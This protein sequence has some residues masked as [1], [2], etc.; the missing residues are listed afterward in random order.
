MTVQEYIDK[1]LPF[2]HITPAKNK[3]K[4]LEQGLLMRNGSI[5]AICTVRIDD[6]DIWCHIAETQLSNGGKYEEFIV[7]KLQPSKHCI[8]AKHVA[9]DTIKEETT[10]LHNYIVKDIKVEEKDF[11]QSFSI[12]RGHNKMIDMSKIECLT[13]YQIQGLPRISKELKEL[14]GEA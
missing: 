12:K 11:I 7:I 14:L 10:P 5:K 2:Y 9:P 8:E 13:G 3:D 4:I 1:N 6:K